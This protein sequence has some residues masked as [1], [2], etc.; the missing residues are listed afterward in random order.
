LHSGAGIKIKRV[1]GKDFLTTPNHQVQQRWHSLAN[2]SLLWYRHYLQNFGRWVPKIFV[3][4]KGGLN[5]KHKFIFEHNLVRSLPLPLPN[6]SS[7]TSSLKITHSCWETGTRCNGTALQGWDV[8]PFVFGAGDLKIREVDTM[9]FS[10]PDAGHIFF[11]S[12]ANCIPNAIV[13]S[14][15]PQGY[16]VDRTGI[17][18]C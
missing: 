9:L 18:T 4:K 11:M 5:W 3:L 17:P 2:D 8:E 6:R 14:H 7:L 1:Q 15:Q 13:L 12:Y 10:N 16:F